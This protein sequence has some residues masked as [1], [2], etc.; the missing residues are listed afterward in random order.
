MFDSLSEKLQD[1]FKRLKGKGRLSEKDVE[2]A[3]KEVRLALLEA[4]VNFKVV[5]DFIEQIKTRA[6][7]KEVLESLTPAQTV[8]KI[9]NEELTDLMG[10]TKSSLSM[11]SNPPTVIMLIGLQGSGKTT[12]TVKLAHYFRKK[13]QTPLLVA[14]DTYRPAA[15]DQLV[16]LGKEIDINVY[17]EKPDNS[18][19]DISLNGIKEA[20]ET[21]ANLVVVDTAGRLHID[22]EMMDELTEIKKAIKPHHILLVVDAMTG[23]EAVNVA[24]SFLGQVGFDGILMT[25][26]DGDARGGAALSIKAVTGKPIKYVSLGEKIDQLDLFYPDRMASRILG[27]GDV[28]TLIEK[29]QEV[30]DAE[31]AE[32]LQ[33]KLL[34]QTFNLED[35]LDQLE[36]IQ[37]MGPISQILKMI[38]GMPG[39]PKLKNLEVSDAE[40]KKIKAI[41]QSMTIDERRNPKIISGS[42]KSRIADGSGTDIQSVNMLLNQFKQAQKMM[43]QL[44]KFKNKLGFDI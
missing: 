15:I 29:T 9:V 8:I 28:L 23:Q 44:S 19:V 32:Q 34:K 10:S 37:K 30:V 14:A 35:F 12:A 22:Q 4:D 13:G 27:M 5:K 3:L 7:G 6:I 43:K 11:A 38:P 16:L 41:I 26:L 33:K 20:T 42:R 31:K 25:K 18:P 21:G 1:V 36:S 40:L 17:T 24:N 39:M 2:L